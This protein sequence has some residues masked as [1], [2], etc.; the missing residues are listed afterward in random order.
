MSKRSA[1]GA[2]LVHALSASH[3]LLTDWRPRSAGH[4]DGTIRLPFFV[5]IGSMVLATS[6]ITGTWAHI[7]LLRSCHGIKIEFQRMMLGLI[8]SSEL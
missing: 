6:S 1:S 2:Q 4:S 8:E 5:A 7:D 3:C